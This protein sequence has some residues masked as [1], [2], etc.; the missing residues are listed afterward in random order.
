MFEIKV[1]KTLI[2][3]TIIASN[4]DLFSLLQNSVRQGILTGFKP[5]ST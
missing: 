5:L 2:V 4:T 3:Y 1:C